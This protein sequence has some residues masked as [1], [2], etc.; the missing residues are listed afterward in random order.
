MRGHPWVAERAFCIL[1][2]P[3]SNVE[4]QS[5]HNSG[6]RFM[7][8]HTWFRDEVRR[9]PSKKF[10][11]FAAR[12][13]ADLAGSVNKYGT[14]PPD[15]LEFVQELGEARLFRALHSPWHY[16]PV[17]APSEAQPEEPNSR[18]GRGDPLRLK[19]G[20]FINT[21]PVWYES[22]SGSSFVNAQLFV[23]ISNRRRKVTA[24]FEEWL[25][26]RFQDCRKFFSPQEW[27]DILAPVPPFSFQEQR[28]V[29]AMSEFQFQKAGVT[30]EGDVLVA[31]ENHS[32][33][34]VRYLTVGVRDQNGSTG[35]CMLPTA[36]IG[37]GTSRTIRSEMYKGSMDPYKVE[38][39][40]L[41]LPD[42][43][44]RPYYGEFRTSDIAGLPSR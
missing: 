18:P 12:S 15:Y 27:K 17:F 42:P 24:T 25:L 43:E 19:I 13:S 10:Y 21:G 9:V 35:S 41:P 39:F 44:D 31:V 23:A 34:S 1:F 33:L 4:S 7:S 2:V 5:Q 40:R 37:P 30:P 38:L 14:L 29:A 6:I 3:N 16:L 28:I 8:R 20:H 26:R 32:L 11:V 22:D 36:D